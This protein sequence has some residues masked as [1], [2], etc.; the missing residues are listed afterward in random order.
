MLEATFWGLVGGCALLLGAL[1]GLYVRASPRT[2]AAVMALG[3][4]VLISA[5]AFDLTAEAYADG[6]VTAVVVGMALGACTFFGGDR[7]LSR[8]GARDRKRS[9]GRSRGGSVPASGGAALALGALLDGIP[10]SAAIGLGLLGDGGVGIAMVA[11]VFL[12]NIPEGWSSASGMRHDGRSPSYVLLLWSGVTVASALAA[13]LGYV[14]LD[15][16]SGVVVGGVQAFAAGAIITMLAD[17]MVP[18]A[19]EEGGDAVGLI[20]ALGFA[21]AFLL[22]QI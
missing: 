8:R 18:E 5:V 11:A 6:G 9:R 13:L 21:L 15:S 20:T 1:L 7:L 2:I 16:A 4:G 22:G 12:S 19:Y 10:E 14:L 3:A 17:T